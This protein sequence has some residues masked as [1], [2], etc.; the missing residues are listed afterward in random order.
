MP[1][2]KMTGRLITIFL[3]FQAI[4]NLLARRNKIHHLDKETDETLFKVFDKDP[5]PTQRTANSNHVTMPSRNWAMITENSTSNASSHAHE[6]ENISSEPSSDGAATVS[7]PIEGSTSTANGFLTVNGGG[8]GDRPKTAATASTSGLSRRLKKAPSSL[9]TRN[10]SYTK[11]SRN[12]SINPAFKDGHFPLHSGEEGAG[13]LHRAAGENHG[14]AG[15]GSLDVMIRVEIDQHDREG[16]TMGYGLQIPLLNYHASM[17][18]V[19]EDLAESEQN[20]DE[21]VATSALFANHR[22]ANGDSGVAGIAG[23]FP[24]SQIKSGPL[25]GAEFTNGDATGTRSE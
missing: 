3:S 2:F 12:G 5:G 11:K 13:T 16:T 7:D 9:A 17:A 1:V 8:G 14:M 23:S 19:T 22:E 4:A 20:G 25:G 24:D 18:P 21:S 10:T 15:D 6:P